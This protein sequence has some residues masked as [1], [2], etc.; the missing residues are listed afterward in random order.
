M[1]IAKKLPKE[2][3]HTKKE[4]QEEVISEDTGFI[5]WP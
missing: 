2:S 3:Y 1:K 5:P 4:N